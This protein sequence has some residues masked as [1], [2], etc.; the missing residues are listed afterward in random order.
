MS[1][2]AAF[3]W[4]GALQGF[5][6]AIGIAIKGIDRSIAP[7]VGNRPGPY[8][9]MIWQFLVGWGLCFALGGWLW[10]RVK[11]RRKAGRSAEVALTG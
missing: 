8:S 11:T 3:S 5:G 2:L 7:Y 9:P 6:P 10:K 1:F 4:W